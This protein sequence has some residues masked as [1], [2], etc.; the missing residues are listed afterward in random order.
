MRD[1]IGLLCA[2]CHAWAERTGEPVSLIVAPLLSH[3]GGSAV[4]EDR[5][6]AS[7]EGWFR[8]LVRETRMNEEFLVFA[9]IK[10]VEAW[11]GEWLSRTARGVAA[12]QERDAEMAA[13]DPETAA[14][15]KAFRA[16]HRSLGDFDTEYRRR[17]RRLDAWREGAL[18]IIKGSIFDPPG[19]RA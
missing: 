17:Q 14:R 15:Y 3:T 8:Q 2:A 19:R 7:L 10:A 5:S 4:F 13:S 16:K 11:F 9:A 18:P 12:E 1:W 6:V